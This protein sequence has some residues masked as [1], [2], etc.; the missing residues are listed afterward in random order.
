MTPEAAAQLG[1]IAAVRGAKRATTRAHVAALRLAR[2]TEAVARARDE[3]D[4]ALEAATRAADE[5]D[6]SAAKARIESLRAE[7]TRRRRLEPDGG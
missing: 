3:T 1:V 7:V 6:D 2:A 5:A 4:A